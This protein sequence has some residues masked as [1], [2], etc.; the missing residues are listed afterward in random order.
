MRRLAQRYWD[1]LGLRGKLRLSI[2]LVL[3][4][5]LVPAQF[6]LADCFRHEILTETE[7]KARI[8]ADGV[9]NGMNMLMIAGKISDPE[10]RK[11]YIRKMAASDGVRELRIIRAKQVQ[12][13]FGP[14]LPEEQAQDDLDRATIASAQ[15]RFLL[16][17]DPA[18]PTLRAVLPFVAG[19]D[20]RGTNCLQ[21][22]H[23]RAGSVNGAASVTLDLGADFERI[24]RIERRLWFGQLILQLLLL[25][26]VGWFTRRLIGPLQHLES[27]MSGLQSGDAFLRREPQELLVPVHS[28]DE[29]GR[30]AMA[31][32]NMAQMLRKEISENKRVTGQLAFY[33]ERDALTGLFN[34]LRFQDDLSRTLAAA[35]RDNTTT[36]LLLFDL[37]GFKR[38]NDGY[39][40]DSGDE[41]LTRIA[42]EIQLQVRGHETLYRIGGDE[43]TIIVANTSRDNV[44][45][46]A[47]RIVATVA[48]V[49]FQFENAQ[50]RITASVGIA[51]CPEDAS[52][53]RSLI[54]MADMAM[55]RA[56]K[57]GGNGW[58]CPEH[59]GDISN[60]IPSP[61]Y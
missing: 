47:Q 18:K 53:A 37:D 26:L 44:Q 38:V 17:P 1:A 39:G 29:I 5:V 11:L 16:N 50:V 25:V 15:P 23:V 35:R 49:K 60:E 20:F 45:T 34:R 58:R 40:H 10:Y 46:L 48:A 7:E 31:F 8:T 6:W 32:N 61:T 55:Y 21:C 33:A 13:Q 28:G 3:L 59:R 57:D 51:M 2:Q 52:D 27:V 30:L 4:L 12:D 42:S 24:A 41:I 36:G 22:H 43:F 54:S 9:L 19:T 14:G 56:K